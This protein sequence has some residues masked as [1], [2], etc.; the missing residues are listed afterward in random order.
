MQEATGV[1]FRHALGAQK[2]GSE[3]FIFVLGHTAVKGSTPVA[4]TAALALRLT[5]G[6]MDPARRGITVESVH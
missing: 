1:V 4:V 5:G 3:S 6:N 2:K